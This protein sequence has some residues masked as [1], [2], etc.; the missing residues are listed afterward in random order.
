MQRPLKLKDLLVTLHKEALIHADKNP[1]R[2][3]SVDRP[4]EKAPYDPFIAVFSAEAD[5][6]AKGRPDCPAEVNRIGQGDRRS[7]LLVDGRE[8]G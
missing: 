1:Y 7:K 6:F 2:G 4:R 3:L 5:A 8:E